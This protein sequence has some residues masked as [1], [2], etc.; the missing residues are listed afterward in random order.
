MTYMLKPTSRAGFYIDSSGQEYIKIA[1]FFYPIYPSKIHIDEVQILG[2]TKDFL[3]PVY[4]T[5]TE[6]MPVYL[7]DCEE[8]C[9]NVE[10]EE[11]GENTSS[12]D[13]K[14]IYT[15]GHR[16]PGSMPPQKEKIPTPDEAIIAV[17]GGD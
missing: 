3:A 9:C 4:Y 17:S 2:E 7:D 6:P 5:K 8:E 13:T 1:K 11:D 16:I 12:D 15:G 14:R 10:S